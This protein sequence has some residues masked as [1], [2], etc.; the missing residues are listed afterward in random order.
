MYMMVN[1]KMISNVN[2]RKMIKLASNRRYEWPIVRFWYTR[3]EGQTIEE[4]I[5][6]DVMFFE[7]AVSHFQNVTPKQAALYKQV[8]GKVVPKEAIQD[9]EPYEWQKGDPDRLYTTLCDTQDL[10]TTIYRFRGSEQ[11][12]LF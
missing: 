1:G 5:N 10:E 3:K 4:I 6:S 8:T 7:W 2:Q 9:V 11:L 12:S